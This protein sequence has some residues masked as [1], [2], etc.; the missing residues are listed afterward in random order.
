MGKR[1]RGMKLD[2]DTRKSICSAISS[3]VGKDSVMERWGICET[4]YWEYCDRVSKKINVESIDT[5]SGRK[6]KAS[7]T[8]LP[9][10][11]FTEVARTLSTQ[12]C[13][14]VAF[15]DRYFPDIDPKKRAAFG[16]LQPGAD[17][18][19]LSEGRYRQMIKEIFG[20]Y[21]RTS[22]IH[23][24]DSD[25]ADNGI[26]AAEFADRNKQLLDQA[27]E[28]IRVWEEGTVAVHAVQV[29]WSK[30]KSSEGERC[31]TW[32]GVLADRKAFSDGRFKLFRIGRYRDDKIVADEL[33]TFLR[34]TDKA[35]RLVCEVKDSEKFSTAVS[36]IDYLQRKLGR[37]VDIRLDNLASVG[38]GVIPL[39]TQFS[40]E[41]SMF[42]AIATAATTTISRK[43]APVLGEKRRVRKKA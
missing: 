33:R 21:F 36:N 1:G 7:M 43:L 27:R 23:E 34:A 18:Y 12:A 19:A 39:A 5:K 37:D 20:V 25:D 42:R 40:S 31:L 38:K 16:R 4:T 15:L 41:T 29:Q 6:G 10:H 17:S 30:K 2:N 8:G 9:L 14:I 32:I 11:I 22:K 28:N 35:I 3:G 13:L 26:P 24:S